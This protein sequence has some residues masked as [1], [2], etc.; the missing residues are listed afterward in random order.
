MGSH[1]EVT[2]LAEGEVFAGRYQLG[3]PL[4]V[5][6]L[7]RVFEAEHGATG[8]QVALKILNPKHISSAHHRKRFRLEA[9]NASVLDHP[10]I[11]KIVDYGVSE[12]GDLPYIAMELLVGRPLSDLL[13][14]DGP[15]EWA[16]AVTIT[17]QLLDALEMAHSHARRIIHRDIKPSNIV[18]LDGMPDRIKVVDFGISKALDGTHMQTQGITGSPHTMAPEQWT[19]KG[20]IGPWTDIYAL[21]CTVFEMVSGH[22][23]FDAPSIDTMGQAHME[24]EPPKATETV[25]G[26]PVVLSDWII[27]AMAKKPEAR[28]ATASEARTALEALEVE[29]PEVDAQILPPPPTLPGVGRNYRLGDV[30]DGRF[31]IT[32]KLGSGGFATVYEGRQLN[33]DRRVAIKILDVYQRQDDPHSKQ[34]EVRFQREASSAAQIAHPGVVNIYD[35]GVTQEGEPYIVME[36]LKGHDLDDELALHG[37]MDPK[38]AVRLAIQALAALQAAHKLGIVHRDLKPSN[39]FLTEPGERDEMLRVVDFG[40]AAIQDS[41]EK[42]TQSGQYL[43]TPRYL[44]PEYVREQHVS[45]AIDVYQMGLILIEML[46]AEPVVQGTS[47]FHSIFI[48]CSGELEVPNYLLESPLGLV[49]GKALSLDP[50]ERYSDAGSLRDALEALDLDQMTMPP[51]RRP[52]KR[53]LSE[54]SSEHSQRRW[55]GKTTQD[56]IA[57]S[58][59]TLDDE[60]DT[61]EGQGTLPDKPPTA[62]HDVPAPVTAPSEVSLPAAN[63]PVASSTMIIGGVVVLGLV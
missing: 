39:L 9:R 6:A 36:Y 50:E 48:H 45:P 22:P 56:V 30:L 19:G 44:A 24:R 13:K 59:T 33:I 8:R 62:P 5:G 54:F 52:S 12:A 28:F 60:K 55:R 31:E 23:P 21:G 4:G 10:N 34:F 7:G 16:R 47:V 18:V 53:K 15:L 57:R 37:P 61:L 25:A 38:R 49:L 63:P 41:G 58:P 46:T 51:M 43:G 26:V 42:L 40:I 17:H 3:R 27:K 35:Y 11:V 1:A 14:E 32:G 2:P 29:L 20:A